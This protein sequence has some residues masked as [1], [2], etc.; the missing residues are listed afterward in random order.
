MAWAC[1]APLQ[2]A[3]AAV[4]DDLAWLSAAERERWAG[5][6]GAQRRRQFVAGR[7]LARRLLAHVGAGELMLAL[8]PDGR[9]TAPPPWRLSISHSGDW[10]GVAAAQGALA[11]LDLQVE[12]TGRDWRALATFA[13][14]RPCPDAAYFYRHWTL[15]E[16]WLKA[17]PGIASLSALRG[18][19]WRP[20]A[21]GPAWQGQ[22]GDLHWA[23]VGAAAPA[24]V[25]DLLPQS[26]WTAAG[27]G[28]APLGGG[29]SVA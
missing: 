2:Q 23:F 3:L 8:D 5:F 14:L 13:G 27:Q 17:H 25:D 20:D 18:L 6:A 10:I 19:R 4:G 24:W 21:A 7:W 29:V 11:G 15:A 12:A 16:A 22:V 1:A 26:L 28:W 9:C